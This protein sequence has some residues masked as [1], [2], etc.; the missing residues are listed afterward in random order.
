MIH[1]V[2]VHWMDPKWIAPQ[3]EFL[4][5]NVE[6]PYRTW[7]SLEGITDPAE[8]A[9]FD[10][11]EDFEGMHA[12][13]LNALAE[14]VVAEADPEDLLV[15]IDGDA[16]P[17]RPIA[18]WMTDLL[19]DV[20]LAAVRRDENQGERQPHPCFCV[21]T[22]GLWKQIGGDWRSGGTWTS[23]GGMQ[24]T[25]VGGTLYT[26]L[27][28]AG[29]DWLPLLRSNTNEL[30]PLWFAV[31]AQHVYHHGA[32]FRRRVSRVDVASHAELASPRIRDTARLYRQRH[33]RAT[34]LVR[35]INVTTMRRVW[36][37][38]RQELPGSEQSRYLD[39]ATALSDEVYADL[40]AHPD[41]F[42]RFETG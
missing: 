21:T 20:P 24:V 40:V 1:I 33:V 8:R 23:P 7:A 5:L 18:T 29:I 25:D 26:Q 30:H 19:G 15:F 12:D 32:G 39:G 13:K 10:V 35:R 11:V 28:S 22:V 16:F 37:G 6:L 31:Y 4:R 38:L 34:D 17:I 9:R 41:F 36:S 14:L 42:L 3:T 2:T 27:R